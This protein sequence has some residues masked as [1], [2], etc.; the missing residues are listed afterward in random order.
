MVVGRVRGVLAGV[1]GEEAGQDAFRGAGRRAHGDDAEVWEEGEAHRDGVVVVVAA[2]ATSLALFGGSSVALRS[3]TRS[4]GGRGE[5]QHQ[6]ERTIPVCGSD[7]M[8]NDSGCCKE[9]SAE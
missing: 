2:A 4:G 3:Q 1:V 7:S 8:R 9:S 5:L 6:K